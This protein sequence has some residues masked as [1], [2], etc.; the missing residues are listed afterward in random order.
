MPDTQTARALIGHTSAETA[1]V[2]N[3]YPYG[4]ARCRIRYWLETNKKGTRLVSQTEHP[5]TKRWNAPKPSTYLHLG[6]MMIDD[7]GH[8]GWSGLG[9]YHCDPE[10]VEAFVR[11]FPHMVSH[12]FI[13]QVVAAGIRMYS[14]F[15]SG[16][17]VQRVSVN[18]VEQIRSAEEIA[19]DRERYAK[20]LAAWRTTEAA[21]ASVKASA[22]TLHE[23]AAVAS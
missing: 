22:S 20:T 19:A 3:D 4:S 6:A 18:G 10:K 8:V 15:A 23:A 12:P 13:D 7:N 14:D 2:V 9:E 17:L 11:M 5:R 16:R 21:V 1:Y